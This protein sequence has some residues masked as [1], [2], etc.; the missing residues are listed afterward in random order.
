MAY[1]IK[2]E[3]SQGSSTKI[4]AKNHTFYSSCVKVVALKNKEI[5]LHIRH[6]IFFAS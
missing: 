4:A 3:Y 2:I 6:L 5:L 1:Y